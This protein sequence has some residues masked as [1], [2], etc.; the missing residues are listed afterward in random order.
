LP[1]CYKRAYRGVRWLA[2]VLQ[3]A[4]HGVTRGLAMVLQDGLPIVLQKAC[5]GVTRGLAVVL[6]EL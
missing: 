6:V 1:W 5:H 2:I 4:C 3:K